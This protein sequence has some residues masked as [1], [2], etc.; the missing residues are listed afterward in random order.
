MLV[1]VII[2]TLTS[3]GQV[4]GLIILKKEINELRERIENEINRD[5]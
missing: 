3:I 2:F 4:L 5:S 1:Y